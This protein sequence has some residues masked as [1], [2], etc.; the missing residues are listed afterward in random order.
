[1]GKARPITQRPSESDANELPSKTKDKLCTYYYYRR[2]LPG[3]PGYK[4]IGPILAMGCSPHCA[5]T[6]SFISSLG[7]QEKEMIEP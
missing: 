7:N 1:M 4:D 6:A 3:A 2:F 5:S